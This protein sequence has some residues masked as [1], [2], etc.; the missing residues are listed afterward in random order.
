MP[1][2]NSADLRP[3]EELEEDT[4]AFP[5]HIHLLDTTRRAWQILREEWWALIVLSSVPVIVKWTLRQLLDVARFPGSLFFYGYVD[6]QGILLAVRDLALTGAW[7]VVA[8][9]FAAA[10][11][12]L[13]HRSLT[14]RDHRLITVLEPS[15][16]PLM[17]L[18]LCGLIIGLAA[19]SALAL[20]TITGS[21]VVYLSLDWIFQAVAFVVGIRLV[22]VPFAIV[23]EKKGLFEA[24]RYSFG[25]T[26]YN[27]FRILMVEV[28]IVLPVLGFWSILSLG[29]S[30]LYVEHGQDWIWWINSLRVIP[31]LMTI[32]ANAARWSAWGAVYADR[33]AYS[34][35]KSRS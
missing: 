13:V 2:G 33:K 30:R 29:I 21:L 7:I 1:E 25:L 26:R 9:W 17:L 15:W 31:H 5:A 19:W 27:F 28:A 6:K 23:V 32:F 8:S 34:V 10:L 22:L 18:S 20:T 14:G 24:L 3:E 35:S 12:L 11:T 16:K 4:F